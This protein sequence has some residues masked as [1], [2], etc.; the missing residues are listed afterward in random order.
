MMIAPE[1]ALLDLEREVMSS[2]RAASDGTGA[3][4]GLD[5]LCLV[6]VP[7]VPEVQLYLARDSTVWWARMQA[8]S[9]AMSAPPYWASA[10]AGGQ[11]VARYVLD[12]PQTVAGR[13]VLDV[14]CGSGLVAIAAAKAG[15]FSIIAND[16]DPYAVAVS[17]LNARANAVTIAESHGDLLDGDGG[18]AEVVLAG[19]AFY[20]EPLA[21]RMLAF[22]ERA[23]ARGAQVLV[24]DPGRGHLPADR[25]QVVASYRIPS[26]D[27][28]IDAQLTFM[29]VCRPRRSPRTSS[30]GSP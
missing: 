28:V 8:R 19:D 26:D 21:L 22:L 23:A 11:A 4:R 17:G 9:P 10:W 6:K 3:A 16:I 1:R 27:A 7:F 5:Q 25:V 29:S 30:P 15:A 13:R 18:D 24:G 12:N 14:A 20:T 2:G